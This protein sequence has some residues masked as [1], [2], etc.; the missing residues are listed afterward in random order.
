[1]P[2]A[3]IDKYE[4]KVIN[5]EEVVVRT[6]QW[7]DK[8]NEIKYDFEF[9]KSGLPVF[10]KKLTFKDYVGTDRT[11]PRRLKQFATEFGDKFKDKHLYFYSK[12]NGTQKTTMASI[13][14]NELIKMGY[15]VKFIT[16]GDF[17][18]DICDKNYD[19]DNNID[20]MDFD[21]LIIDDAFDTKKCTI[22][23]STGYQIGYLDP[24]LRNRLEILGK[25]TCFTSNIP[26]NEI[27]DT[28]GASIKSL[29]MRNCIDMEFNVSYLESMKF[30]PKD[31]WD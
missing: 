15:S 3:D 14:G 27:S 17:L 13:L 28:F 7:K 16:M 30:D 21:F 26:M 19:G 8:R 12:S 29:I 23:H 25:S 24:I 1:M 11:I 2:K 6:P 22:S 4:V 20:Y 9:Q 10:C 18:K 31:L 5:G